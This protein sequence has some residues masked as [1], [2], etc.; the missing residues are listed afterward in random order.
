M[1]GCREFFFYIS[2]NFSGT[3]TYHSDIKNTLLQIL[4]F[5][6]LAKSYFSKFSKFF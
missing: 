4:N 3:D 5:F 1:S 6:L 2:K